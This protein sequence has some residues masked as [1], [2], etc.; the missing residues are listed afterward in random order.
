MTSA[1]YRLPW[2]DLL[3]KFLPWT[4]SHGLPAGGRL[5]VIAFIAVALV[6]TKRILNHLG[7]DAS[8]LGLPGSLLG[9]PDQWAEIFR[10]TME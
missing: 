8:G 9:W 10:S 1:T 5:Q 6:A 2:A 4:S 7:L 3:K